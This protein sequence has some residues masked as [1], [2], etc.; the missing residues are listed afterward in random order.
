[1]T[2]QELIEEARALSVEERATLVKALV[3]ML[4]AA[5]KSSEPAR[6]GLLAYRGLGAHLSD[7]TDPQTAISRLRDEWDTAP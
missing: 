7:D 2:L 1:M 4:A 3:D 6:P 5:S